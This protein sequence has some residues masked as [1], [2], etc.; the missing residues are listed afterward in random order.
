MDLYQ[1]LRRCHSEYVQGTLAHQEYD[2]RRAALIDALTGTHFQ[3]KVAPDEPLLPYVE[4]GSTLGTA[5]ERNMTYK[6]EQARLKEGLVAR[7]R[8][9]MA[10][11]AAKQSGTAVQDWEIFHA[12]A[13]NNVKR[14]TELVE[15]G[16]PLGLKDK[17]SGSTPLIMAASRGQRQALMWLVEH[18]ADVN[19][20]NNQGMTALHLLVIAKQT[21]LCV[22]LVKQGAD[23]DLEDARNFSSYDMALP[24]LQKELKEAR[25][26]Y[27][28][29]QKSAQQ[30][31]LLQQQQQQQQFIQQSGMHQLGMPLMML[32]QQPS[33]TLPSSSIMPSSN[34]TTTIPNTTTS[35]SNAPALSTPFS[36]Q[37][38]PQPTPAAL[39]H[40]A[41]ITDEP[42][43]TGPL[44]TKVMKLYLK[45]NAYKTLMLNSGMKAG[46][47]CALVAEKLGMAEFA[48]S[49]ELIDC[50]KT[51]ER[52]VDPNVN[53]FRLTRSWPVIINTNEEGNLDD[54]CR[55]K[56]VPVRGCSEAVAAK[57][58]SAMY[59]K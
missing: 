52:R 51:N 15:L 37:I 34:P 36:I 19:A 54:T 39:P 28:Q 20:Q 48:N 17:D 53:V 30:Q 27:Q 26:I 21:V 41:P 44:E 35:M 13:N 6:Y 12:A 32:P 47:V 55:L 46:D 2:I 33:T 45:N 38:D 43:P 56:V 25:D 49:L 16:V 1:A 23:I 8:L 9:G 5:A 59:G 10:V 11:E 18:G 7:D 57:Y 4:K 50:I 3:P 24:W 58:R 40:L 31:Q 22:W 29:T 14:L 42:A